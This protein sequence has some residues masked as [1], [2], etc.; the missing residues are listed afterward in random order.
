MSTVRAATGVGC[1]NVRL[2]PKEESAVDVQVGVL[3]PFVD[4]LVTDGA[5][6]RSFLRVVEDCG[7]E[8]VW[9]VEHVVVA[10]DYEP[11][12]PYSSDGRMPS[13]TAA[14]MPD[15]LELLAFAAAAT[16]RL[17]LGTGVVVAPLHSPVMLAKR[18]ATLDLLSGGRLL[19]GLGIGW[20]REEYAAV[21]APFAARGRR[22]EDG[23]G[24]M[25]AL[26]AGGAASYAGEFVNLD[27]VD[28]TIAPGRQIPILLGGNSAPAVNR[29]GRI[30]DGWLPYTISPQDF[31]AGADALRAA[32]KAAGRDPGSIEITAWPG[33]F[34]PAR[35]GEPAFL[36]EYL[37]S[38]ASRLLVAPRLRRPDD[39]D[40]LRPQLERFRD[41]VDA[42]S[43][44]LVAQSSSLR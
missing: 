1:V 33:S 30:A 9:A 18:T 43:S 3:F 12:Y 29:A 26:W 40:G 27:R 42:A 25:R 17:R 14:P 8:S 41:A 20:Q 32:A 31:A 16:D 2:W 23:I 13:A 34:D 19:L 24:A 36:A 11:R 21:G 44:R 5:F 4:G 6:L 39:L 28:L 15:P 37:R 10:A 35:Q 7:V 22:L 38:G